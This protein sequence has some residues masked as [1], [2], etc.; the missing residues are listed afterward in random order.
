MGRAARVAAARVREAT[1]AERTAALRLMAS[2]LRDNAMAILTANAEDLA[3]ARAADLD[4]A[5]TDRLTLDE[6]RLEGVAR[7]VDDIA[8]QADPVG[9]E[10]AR[11]T[12]P[13]GLDI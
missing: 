7:A 1:A 10:I 12:R 6:K 3:A 8:G 5:R 11:W 9:E 13:N 4:A 2:A